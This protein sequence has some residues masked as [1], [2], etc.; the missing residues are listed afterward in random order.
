MVFGCF[1]FQP[2]KFHDL[3]FTK[4]KYSTLFCTL[5]GRLQWKNLNFDSMKHSNH[6]VFHAIKMM[7]RCISP[8]AA[9]NQNLCTI[10]FAYHSQYCAKFY[11]QNIQYSSIFSLFVFQI[12]VICGHP[13]G[14]TQCWKEIKCMSISKIY[15][16]TIRRLIPLNWFSVSFASP[17]FVQ[18]CLQDRKPFIGRERKKMFITPSNAIWEMGNFD[19]LWIN[20]INI[21]WYQNVINF[22]ENILFSMFYY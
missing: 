6:S 1:F 21:L 22:V 18:I 13:I 14:I 3:N 8:N 2:V 4:L 7:F 16:Q 12:Q 19:S 15:D 10:Q 17:F 5:I 20:S 11:L 9:T